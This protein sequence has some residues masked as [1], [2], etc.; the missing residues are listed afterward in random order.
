MK[1][2]ETNK[3]RT[4]F[5]SI[6]DD[7]DRLNHLFSLG[8]DKSW[9]RRA[10]KQIV[11]PE[12]K[13]AILDVACGTGDFSIAIAEAAHP[14][15]IVTGLDLSDGMLA[16]MAKKVAQE[17]LTARIHTEQGNSESM[18]WDDATFDRVTI[19]FGIRNFEHREDAL[20]EIFRVLKPGGKLVILELSVPSNKFIRWIYNFYFTKIMPWLGG[21]ISGDR[22]A[23]HYLPASVLKFPKK[24]EWM[25]TMASCGYSNV[26][27]KAFT[28]GI[29]RMYIG[30]K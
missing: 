19:A 23:Y 2:P 16:V 21:K 18:R 20:K 9:R 22:A 5:D 3:I 11:D 12:K 10:L 25:H 13:Q 4:M 17:G 29:C 28:L 14:E 6:A 26:S 8:I 15:T 30:E 27:H 7:Y 1:G 24:L